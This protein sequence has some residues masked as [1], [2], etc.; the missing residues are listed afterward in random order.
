[1]LCVIPVRCLLDDKVLRRLRFVR[2]LSVETLSPDVVIIATGAMPPIP[3]IPGICSAH[4]LTAVD[5]LVTPNLV[6]N[7]VAVVGRGLVGC[8]AA[9]FLAVTGK[10]LQL[11]SNRR[12]CAWMLNLASESMSISACLS[13]TWR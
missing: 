8:E 4:I 5:A 13:R 10:T 7:V 12:L 1:M 9:E 3:E 6:G 2:P 11:L